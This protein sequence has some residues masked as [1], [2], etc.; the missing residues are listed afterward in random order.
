[1]VFFVIHSTT[2]IHAYAQKYHP[3]RKDWNHTPTMKNG[4]ES[5]V[6]VYLNDHLLINLTTWATNQPALNKKG[7]AEHLILAA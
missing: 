7:I 6:S 1:M 3:K 2:N 5:P 4:W